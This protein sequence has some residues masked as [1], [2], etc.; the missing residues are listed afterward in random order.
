MKRAAPFALAAALSAC[1]TTPPAQSPRAE[2]PR[3]PAQD[4]QQWCAYITGFGSEEVCGI[5]VPS[6]ESLG[7][8]RTGEKPH[9]IALAPDGSRFYVSNE[10]NNT[11]SV[12]DASAMGVVATIAVGQRPNQI[13]LTPDGRS[14]W[15]TNYADHSVSVV[16]TTSNE[17]TRTLEVGRN[18]HIVAMNAS[19]GQALV[20]SEG[21]GAVDVFDLDTFERAQRIEVFGFPRVLTVAPQG[22]RAFLT[23]RWLNGALVLDLQAGA[24]GER[25]SVGERPFAEAGKVAHGIAVTHDGELVL[26]TTQT[27]G[28]LTWINAHT[29]AAVGNVRVGDDP[30]WVEVT[31]DDRYA[32]VSN[33]AEDTAVVVDVRQRSIL[34]SSS[35]SAKPKRLTVGACPEAALSS[36]GE[37][38]P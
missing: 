13:A 21:D 22:D 38:S 24:V 20:T 33:T 8:V 4:G 17:V 15:V 12:V 9:G 11:V 25:F 27:S 23:L 7:C 16:D 10:G 35:V 37:P 34:G 6:A 29:S 28:Q 19:R 32:V 26:L 18:P 5:R 30:N 14:L 31:P 3:A 36:K 2:H 1:A